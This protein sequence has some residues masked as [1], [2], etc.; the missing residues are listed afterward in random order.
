MGQQNS[1]GLRDEFGSVPWFH[2]T[3]ARSQEAMRNG[4]EQGEVNAAVDRARFFRLILQD[5]QHDP[6]PPPEPLDTLANA[7]MEEKEKQEF[8]P[9]EW[10]RLEAERKRRQAL[11]DA[12]CIELR[13]QEEEM[14]KSKG[15]I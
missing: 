4:D 12:R 13:K 3:Y 11:F 1:G 2:E 15:D 7:A 5:D 9:E 8:T 14:K 10:E 6:P